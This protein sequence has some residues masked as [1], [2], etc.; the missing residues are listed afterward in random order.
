MSMT[1]RSEAFDPGQPIPKK[2]TGEGR[3]LSPPLR[4]TGAPAETQQ[5][6]LIC[7]DPDAPRP[8]PWVHWVIYKIAPVFD[9]LGEGVA[10]SPQPPSPAG[11]IQGPNSGRR[12][13]YMGPMP[14]RGHGV[15]HYHFRLYALD[16]DLDLSRDLGKDALLEAIEGHVLAETELIGTYER[17]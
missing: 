16:D 2:Y 15:H 4:W 14:P 5:F 3:D 1:L 11:A 10:N 8:E 17:K 13:G 9:S 12:I 7:D 6:V